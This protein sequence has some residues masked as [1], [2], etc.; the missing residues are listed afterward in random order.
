MERASLGDRWAFGSRHRRWIQRRRGSL[1]ASSVALLMLVGI[2]SALADN[3]KNDVATG[4]GVGQNRTVEVGETTTINYFVQATGGTCDPADGTPLSL[5]IN[6]PAV[7]TKTSS[8]LTFTSCTASGSTTTNTQAVT[9]SSSTPGDYEITVTANDADPADDYTVSL[10]TFHL[11]VLSPDS[12]GDG[13]RDDVDNCPSVSNPDQADTDGD[14]IGDA[15]DTVIPPANTPPSVDAGGP[16]SGNEGSNISLNGATASDSDGTVASNVWSIQDDSGVS[17][18]SCTLSNASSPTATINCTDNGSVTVRLTA[19]DDDGASAS[20]D[21]TVTVSNLAP[22]GTFN[23]PGT[24]N[25]GSSF[26]LS[27]TSV[28]DPSVDT[29]TYAFDCGGGYGSFGASSSATCNT[30]TD[31]PSTLSVGGKVR[32]DDGGTSEYTGSVTVA[33][34]AP[35]I[36]NFIVT[37]SPAT[38]C[39]AGN[40]VG[41][42]FTV[43][44]AVDNTVDP[45]TGTINWGDGNTTNISGRTISES[46]TY[47]SAGTFNLTAT[48]NDGDGG[49]DTEGGNGNVSLLYNASGVLQPVND[50]QAHQDPSIFKHGST[51]PVKIR[52]TDC[53]GTVV[54]GLSPV[55]T[56]T[57]VNPN[58]P[59]DGIAETTASTSGAD[60]GTTMRFDAAS[61]QYIYNLATKQLS[62]GTAT[63]KITITGPF[64]PVTA[65]FGLKTK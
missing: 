9:F 41:V 62:D 33:N 65:N 35:E 44:D 22:T 32:D 48:V 38:A 23:K 56:V 57:K 29:F 49:T 20:D 13:D 64:A 19:T 63:Y 26:T 30:A 52:I 28:V 25:E 54:S 40:T 45:I 53:N 16:Y 6:A 36:Q 46:H 17:P 31:G 18:G 58:P 34:V 14:G 27:I 39:L 3:V 4:G 5:T 43:T 21:A 59:P 24:V 10:A 12:D 15:C 51:I 2:T 7:V 47:T 8:S 42:A 60:T 55:I 50:T 1:L 11:I 61:G 37:G